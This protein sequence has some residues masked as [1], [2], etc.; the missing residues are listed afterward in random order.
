MIE[1]DFI[2]RALFAQALSTGWSVIVSDGRGGLLADAFA[3]KTNGFD[4]G[5]IIL[6]K[7]LSVP[8]RRDKVDYTT[9]NPP[10]HSSSC[11]PVSV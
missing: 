6:S 10:C 2:I 4:D 1:R 8:S 3:L 11:L 7:D 5:Q 9:P